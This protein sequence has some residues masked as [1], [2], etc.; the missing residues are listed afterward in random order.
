VKGTP[1]GSCRSTS[2]IGA[3]KARPG[4]PPGS[5]RRRRSTRRCGSRSS[6]TSTTASCSQQSNEATWFLD[7]DI[8]FPNPGNATNA[9]PLLVNTAGS[10][11]KRPKAV[12]RI[13]N[14]FLASDFVQ[15]NTD[16]ATM[17]GANEAARRAVN[18]IL[19]ASGSH[20][21]LCHV[22][23][24]WEPAVLAPFRIADEV[25]WRL[26]L[27]VKLPVKVTPSGQ[28]Q[29]TW[30]PARC[31]QSRAAWVKERQSLCRAPLNRSR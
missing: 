3:P 29:P 20:A 27:D 19:K 1:F 11:A 8:Q 16:L 12:T 15:T 21:K 22:C 23:K 6:P 17:E 10:W 9:E 14:F 30:P 5:A 2:Q 7:P 28:L 31:W 26:G 13:P 4:N 25:R 24:L 18:G